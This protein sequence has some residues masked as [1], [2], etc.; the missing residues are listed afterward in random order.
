M[1]IYMKDGKAVIPRKISKL[2]DLYLKHDYLKLDLSDEVFDYIEE[3]AYL[4]PINT[5]IPI[6]IA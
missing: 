3:V 1:Q 5:I 6:A 4:I 2:S